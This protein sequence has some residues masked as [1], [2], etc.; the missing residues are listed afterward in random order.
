MKIF[1]YKFFIMLVLTLVTYFIYRE[2][3]DLKEKYKK[4]SDKLDKLENNKEIEHNIKPDLQLELPPSPKNLEKEK[5]SHE[6]EKLDEKEKNDLQTG[7]N[8][9][10]YSNDN[11]KNNYTPKNDENIENSSEKTNDINLYENKDEYDYEDLDIYS[12]DNDDKERKESFELGSDLDE[13]IINYNDPIRAKVIENNDINNSELET[14]ENKELKPEEKEGIKYHNT[15]SSADKY[16][17]NKGYIKKNNSYQNSQSLK[18]SD[19]SKLKLSDLQ[20]LAE[21]KMIDLYKFDEKKNKNVK[22]T[23]KDLIENLDNLENTD[24]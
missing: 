17:E 24:N 6:D 4:L 18:K 2:L 14:E 22:K 11:E 19:L 13:E 15:E 5:L 20:C 9:D 23:K 16:L 10:T 7:E 8:I 3:D 12:N 21:E 1:D